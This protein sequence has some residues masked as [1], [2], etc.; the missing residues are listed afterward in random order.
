ME[1]RFARWRKG[2]GRSGRIPHELWRASRRGGG[3]VRRAGRQRRGWGLNVAGLSHWPRAAGEP[4]AV[5]A[6]P[7]FVELAPL[8]LGTTAECTLETEDA[9]GRRVRSSLKRA[10]QALP[11]V[12]QPDPHLLPGQSRPDRTAGGTIRPRRR[13]PP[14]G[15]PGTAGRPW[16]QPP[17]NGLYRSAV[18]PSP[19]AYPPRAQPS[20][21]GSAARAPQPAT[22]P[23]AAPASAESLRFCTPA[24]VTP[25]I[26]RASRT[27]D[28]SIDQA[29]AGVFHLSRATVWELDL[30]SPLSLPCRSAHR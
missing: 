18:S 17:G 19:S 15:C 12:A 4:K 5:E 16:Q 14:T 30:D 28:S 23:H 27:L 10:A 21:P 29:V 26:Q 22:Q 1:R 25:R 6:P 20:L 8:A 11:L 13:H 7:Q 2:R 24:E 9:T 3:G